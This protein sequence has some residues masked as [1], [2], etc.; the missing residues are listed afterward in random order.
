MDQ[1]AGAA[2]GRRPQGQGLMSGLV[3]LIGA[4]RDNP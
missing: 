2:Q 3:F 4:A 1:A